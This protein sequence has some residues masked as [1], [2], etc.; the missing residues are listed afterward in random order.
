MVTLGFV[1]RLPDAQII[2][3]E[4]KD[5]GSI[6]LFTNSTFLHFFSEYFYEPFTFQMIFKDAEYIFCDDKPYYIYIYI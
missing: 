1:E 6:N 3:L 5:S 2:S 4:K